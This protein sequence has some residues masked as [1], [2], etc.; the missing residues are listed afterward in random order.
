[1]YSG[2]FI[3]IFKNHVYYLHRRAVSDRVE[4]IEQMEESAGG[5]FPL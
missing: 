1:M 4:E 5:S 3:S 2:T